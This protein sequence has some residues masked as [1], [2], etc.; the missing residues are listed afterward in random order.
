ME[1]YMETLKNMK[2]CNFNLPF[3]QIENDSPWY[4]SLKHQIK[5]GGSQSENSRVIHEERITTLTP[6]LESDAH[7]KQNVPEDSDWHRWDGIHTRNA[8]FS[9]NFGMKAL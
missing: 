3:I 7:V 6:L 8:F 9:H 2:K 5:V 4:F 1:K